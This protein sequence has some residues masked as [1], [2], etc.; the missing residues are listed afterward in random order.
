[1]NIEWKQEL[2]KP[3]EIPRKVGLVFR[4]LF[5]VENNQ[6]NKGRK[7]FKIIYLRLIYFIEPHNP[8]FPTTHPVPVA[9]STPS[10]PIVGV[11]SWAMVSSFYPRIGHTSPPRVTERWVH[12]SLCWL[13][14]SAESCHVVGQSSPHHSLP[15]ILPTLHWVTINLNLIGPYT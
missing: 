3:E 9:P 12:K 2:K 11:G 7:S 13:A 1:M 15:I 10:S 4:P 14:A 8:R 6:L 5:L